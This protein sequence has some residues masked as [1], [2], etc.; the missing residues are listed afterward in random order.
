MINASQMGIN[1][2]ITLELVQSEGLGSHTLVNELVEGVLSVGSRFPPYNGSSVVIHTGARLGDVLPVG[3]HVSLKEIT[4]NSTSVLLSETIAAFPL[5]M[6][7]KL[8]QYFINVNK[9]V[10]RNDA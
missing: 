5:Q 4:N 2:S 8:K 9:K 6:C 1:M 7:A 10:L 3:L